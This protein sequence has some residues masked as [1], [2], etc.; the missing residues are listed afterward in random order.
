MKQ[1]ILQ[2]KSKELKKEA[3]S[4]GLA[5]L[6]ELDLPR[7][8]IKNK[9]DE[10]KA[11]ELGKSKQQLL[12]EFSD[13][14]IIPL[15]NLIA[16]LKDKTKIF[17]KVTSAKEAKL[18]MET[19]ELGS[20]G[21]VIETEN[22]EEMRKTLDVIL[23]EHNINIEE[24]TVTNI[25][26]LGL[27]ARACIDT[28]DMIKDQAGLLVGSSS[29]GMILVKAENEEAKFVASRPFRVN[30]G[31]VSLYTLSTNRKTKYL[32]E[33]KAGDEV[34]VV[35][36]NGEVRTSNIARSKIELR[37]LILVEATKDNKIAKAVLQNAETIKIVTQNGSK[38]VTE[39]KIGDKIMVHFESGGR[40]FG[41]LV[42]K[43]M[44]IE[45]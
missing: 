5:L 39:L 29:R 36:K 13:Q 12:V 28:C 17:V 35:N 8:E 10:K 37:P 11:I 25:K 4:L 1:V 18:A 44:V 3:K 22:G 23:S 21:V 41:T 42:D 14:K 16:A 27:G 7:I 45:K 32:E 33:L 38:A 40:H 26:Q 43:E 9:E 15:E 19:L 6:E 30:A 24:A 31:A 2:T 34:L 20:D